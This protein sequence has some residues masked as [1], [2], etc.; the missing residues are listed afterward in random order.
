[1][2]AAVATP[3]RPP[4]RSPAA[5]QSHAGYAS[6]SGERLIDDR[7]RLVE[8]GVSEGDRRLAILL[9]LSPLLALAMP[10]ILAVPLVAWFLVRD[11]SA[12]LDDHCRALLDAM[13]S[14]TLWFLIAAATI[15]GVV[16]WPVLLIIALIAMVRAAVDAGSSRYVRYPLALSIL[17]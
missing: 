10:L 3:P 17:S 9:H 14:Y 11:R 4:M 12:F 15:V 7:G 5:S 1:M 2:P 13:I 16:L 8:S 6:A